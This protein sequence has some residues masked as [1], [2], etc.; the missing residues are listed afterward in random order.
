ME[1]TNKSFTLNTLITKQLRLGETM[2]GSKSTPAVFVV[3]FASLI[4]LNFVFHMNVLL[5]VPPERHDEVH[6]TSL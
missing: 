6:R 2:V 5:P 4:L 1:I 3:K